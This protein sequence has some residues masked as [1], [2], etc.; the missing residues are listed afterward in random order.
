MS[1]HRVHGV[2]LA[3]VIATLAGLLLSLAS[4]AQTLEVAGNEKATA[5]DRICEQVMLEAA[6][7]AGITLHVQRRP[8][9]RGS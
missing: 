5:I 6:R 1:L 8:M 9:T 2:R 7:R 4:L 3:R